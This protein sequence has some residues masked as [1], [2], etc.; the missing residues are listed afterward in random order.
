MR[1]KFFPLVLTASCLATTCGG[2]PPPRRDRESELRLAFQEI[3]V[4]EAELEKHRA[5]L[6]AAAG[7]CER[8][9][10]ELDRLCAGSRSICQVARQVM[11]ADALAR[12]ESSRKS[13]RAE[14]GRTHGRCDCAGLP[15][16]ARE[17]GKVNAGRAG[18]SGEQHE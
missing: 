1:S 6:A 3:Q 14:T 10:P 18:A 9:C 16:A 12:C 4:R 8:A 7:A 5:E 2:A 11:D 15:V 17:T 13:C